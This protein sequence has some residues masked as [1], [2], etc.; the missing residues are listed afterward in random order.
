M[1]W[2]FA[3]LHHVA[4]FSLVAAVVVEFV[5]IWD[6]LTVARAQKIQLADLVFQKIGENRDRRKSGQ[7][8]LDPFLDQHRLRIAEIQT[9]Y[10]LQG[11]APASP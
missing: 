6:E 9:R 3:F 7:I 11:D 10:G 5:L 8:Y 1:T 2:L 4:A